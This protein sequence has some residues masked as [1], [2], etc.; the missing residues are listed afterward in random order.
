MSEISSFIISV[1]AASVLLSAVYILCP[2]GKLKAPLKYT[3]S[4]VFL[5][6]V[7]ALSSIG[8]ATDIDL[9]L[10]P[11]DSVDK[12]HAESVAHSIFASALKDEDIEF[13]KIEVLSDKLPDGSISISKVTVWTREN[14]QKITDVIGSDAY[15]VV[16]K[17]E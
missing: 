14:S 5:C 1:S 16:V 10:K 13:K 17:N 9:T 7:C 8:R 15:E 2:E 11:A 12:A 6:C 4:L 3:F